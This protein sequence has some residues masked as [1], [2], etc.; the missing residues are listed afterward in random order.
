MFHNRVRGF[1]SA[2]GLPHG[3]LRRWVVAALTG[4]AIAA[5]MFWMFT[6]LLAVNLPGLTSTGWL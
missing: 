3:G 6:Q 5:P 1:K 4:F 2:Q